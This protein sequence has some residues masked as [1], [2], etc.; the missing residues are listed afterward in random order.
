MFGLVDAG[1]EDVGNGTAA[2]LDRVDIF[3][4]ICGMVECAVACD[5][6]AVLLWMIR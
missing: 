2:W 1:A 5:G 3:W 4:T 6:V